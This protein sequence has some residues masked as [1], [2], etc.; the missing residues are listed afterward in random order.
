MLLISFFKDILGPRF[1]LPAD[2]FPGYDY[3]RP[4]PAHVLIGARTLSPGNGSTSADLLHPPDV[5]SGG[6]IE[7]VICYNAIDTT[8]SPYMVSLNVNIKFI[9]DNIPY[10]HIFST[11]MKHT[12]DT[13]YPLRP[14]LPQSMSGAMAYYEDGVLH[15]Q[16]SSTSSIGVGDYLCGLRGADMNADGY[17][18][19]LS[20]VPLGITRYVNIY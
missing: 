12:Y 3:F 14:S 17:A 6:L 4:V 18:F 16:V 13:D 20:C 19:V 7:C 11:L 8:N 10:H 2:M 1:F 5:E 9:V 15:L